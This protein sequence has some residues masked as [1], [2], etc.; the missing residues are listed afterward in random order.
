MTSPNNPDRPPFSRRD[1][2]VPPATA[3]SPASTKPPS[4]AADTATRIS[5]YSQPADLARGFGTR[6][7]ATTVLDARPILLRRPDSIWARAERARDEIFDAI[8]QLCDRE[9][10]DAQVVKSGPFALPAF[11]RF[12]CWVPVQGPLLTE[13]AAVTISVTARE[14]HRYDLEYGLEIADRGVVKHHRRLRTFDAAMAT[15]LISYLLR[16]GPKPGY[17]SAKLRELEWQIWRPK[18]EVDALGRDW[19]QLGPLALAIIGYSAFQLSVLGLLAIAAAVAWWILLARRP[20][21]VQSS[22]K[23]D[24]EPRILV[25]LD[26]WQA[27]VQGLGGD[28]MLLRDRLVDEIRTN[29]LPHLRAS[30]EHIWH[31]GLDGTE[32][33]EQIVLGLGRALC[34]CHVYQYGNDVYV[35]WDGHVNYGQWVERRIARGWSRQ[36]QRLTDIQTVEQGFQQITEYDVTDLNLL[37]EWTH[38]KLTEQVKRLL[39]ERRIDAEIDFT[40]QRG[41]RQGLTERRG[42]NEI[43]ETARNAAKKLQ[44]KLTRT[45]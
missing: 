17:E 11:V 4:P 43:G 26:S 3:R 45:G 33:R 19:V 9:H 2:G 24:A 29:S 40:I 20:V 7:S 21:A 25:A 18:N 31:W 32:E 36:A 1:V 35:G 38:N 16:R 8:T 12:E 39:A 10:V 28:A 15:E 42:I 22:G 13:R 34:F 37:M 5:S 27:M 6:T 30:I 41:G 44:R 14:F 23:P